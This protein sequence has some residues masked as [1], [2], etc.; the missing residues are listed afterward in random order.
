MESLKS[1]EWACQSGQYPKSSLDFGFDNM[2]GDFIVVDVQSLDLSVHRPKCSKLTDKIFFND[3][4][5]QY[6][7]KKCLSSTYFKANVSKRCASI[8]SFT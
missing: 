6:E 8:I 3:E 4:Q 7:V 5:K 1:R 2:P